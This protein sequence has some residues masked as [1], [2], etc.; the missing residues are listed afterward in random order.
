[1]IPREVG[2]RVKG[3]SML[4]RLM[5]PLSGSRRWKW[6]THSSGSVMSPILSAPA[7]FTADMILMT[8]L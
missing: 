3:A 7:S 2:R 6:R 8:S 4:L 1:M 5:K